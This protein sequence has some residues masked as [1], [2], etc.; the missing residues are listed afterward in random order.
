LEVIDLREL[1]K[2]EVGAYLNMD[3]HWSQQGVDAVAVFLGKK[4]S[5]RGDYDG[6]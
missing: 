6:R 2:G 3:G 5:F 1:L 4:I